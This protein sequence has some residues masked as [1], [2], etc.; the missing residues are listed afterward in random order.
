MQYSF[1]K[2]Y[3]YLNKCQFQING[4]E[5]DVEIC[6]DSIKKVSSQGVQLMVKEDENSKETVPTNTNH[7]N[8]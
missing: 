3:Y 6:S 2:I 7:T 8:L 4:N 5:F 1:C